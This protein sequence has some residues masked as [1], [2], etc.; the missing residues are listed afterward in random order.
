VISKL[1]NAAD[2][3]NIWEETKPEEQSMSRSSTGLYFGSVDAANAINKISYWDPPK[4]DATIPTTQ[5]ARENVVKELV[6]MIKNNKGCL[7]LNGVERKAFLN[8][9]GD[10]ADLFD[11]WA[12]EAV[13]WRILVSFPTLCN[14]TYTDYNSN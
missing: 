6:I 1:Q 2:K 8:R 12:I 10:D 11:A 9:W 3:L 5:D 14:R 7:V 4:N 13:A